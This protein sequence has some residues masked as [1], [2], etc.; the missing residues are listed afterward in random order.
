MQSLPAS[1]SL[2]L[3]FFPSPL[4]FSTPPH[5]LSHHLFLRPF[6]LSSW[7]AHAVKFRNLLKIVTWVS[8]PVAPLAQ[9]S[10]MMATGLASRH[11]AFSLMRKKARTTQPSSFWDFQPSEAT[12]LQHLLGIPSYT[13]GEKALLSYIAKPI[14]NSEYENTFHW[15]PS[16]N[17]N[18]W[19][20]SSRSLLISSTLSRSQVLLLSDI[21]LK[22]WVSKKF[23][24][25]LCFA[26]VQ[27]GGEGLEESL[28]I[29]A[30]QA[31]YSRK[32]RGFF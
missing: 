10:F 27:V 13:F 22:T 21:L 19:T 5:H 31:T 3:F 11:L 9:P 23:L 4:P 7:E 6:A 20:C 15:N 2:S 8:L 17:I 14:S 30:R 1:L 28:F 25:A 18:T 29:N 26:L 16:W 24:K 32:A 12:T